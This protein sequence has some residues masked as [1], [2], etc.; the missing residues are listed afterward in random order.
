MAT[1]RGWRPACTR[2]P[3]PLRLAAVLLSPVLPEQAAETWRR[4]GWQPPA[5]PGSA[6]AW[7]GLQPGSPVTSG[8]PLFPRIEE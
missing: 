7:G 5:D 2:W 6:L 3:K 8:E 4:L 1:P